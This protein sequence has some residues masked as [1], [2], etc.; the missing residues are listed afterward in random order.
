[1]TDLFVR[2]IRKDISFKYKRDFDKPDAWDNNDANNMLD[3][4]LFYV[5]E[6]MI[7]SAKCQTVANFP[8]GR[9]QDTIAA[10]PFSLKCFVPQRMFH[11]RVHGIVDCYDIEGQH[12]DLDSVQIDDKNR[13]LVHDTQKLKPN[14]PGNLTRVA[15][16][17]GCFVLSK[18]DLEGLNEIL[19]AYKIEAGEIIP[20]ELVEE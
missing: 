18:L 10:G 16:S 13:W 11:C 3:S 5:D 19:D 7:F 6:G 12:I 14:P 2:I 8:G 15:W 9:Y 4:F 1:M 17:A 20:G